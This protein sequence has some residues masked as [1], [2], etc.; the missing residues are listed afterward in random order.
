MRDSNPTLAN[1]SAARRV[2]SLDVIPFPISANSTFS[3][4]VNVGQQMEFLKYDADLGRAQQSPD[5]L[6][7]HRLFAPVNSPRRRFVAAR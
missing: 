6:I 7:A 1:S 2:R 3:I 4:A 5:A